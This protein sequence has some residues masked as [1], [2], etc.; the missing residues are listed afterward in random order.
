MI[1]SQ[2]LLIYLERTSIQRMVGGKIAL[3][4]ANSELYVT[5]ARYTAPQSMVVWY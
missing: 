1:R 4:A 2:S 3:P 5:V